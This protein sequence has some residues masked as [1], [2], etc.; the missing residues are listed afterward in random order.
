MVTTHSIV[1]VAVFDDGSRTL[2]WCDR[3]GP[4]R[5]QDDPGRPEAVLM[6][7]RLALRVQGET[8]LFIS[9]YV[10]LELALGFGRADS[11]QRSLLPPDGEPRLDMVP[12]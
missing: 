8:L 10:L 11:L 9:K 5:G 12:L 2:G 7:E 3:G 1:A 6:P 4:L